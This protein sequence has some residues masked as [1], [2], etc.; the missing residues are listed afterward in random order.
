MEDW[1]YN[2]DYEEDCLLVSI[3]REVWYKFTEVLEEHISSI[4]GG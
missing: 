2:S 4:F 3:R 1:I